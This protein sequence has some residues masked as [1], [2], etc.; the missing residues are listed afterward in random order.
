MT[1]SLKSTDQ[2]ILFECSPLRRKSSKPP[3]LVNPGVFKGPK[4]RRLPETMGL[5][6]SSCNIIIITI[7]LLIIIISHVMYII[8][9]NSGPLGPY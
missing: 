2:E 4:T 7:I 6:G 8:I 5:V 1:D 3:R 9:I